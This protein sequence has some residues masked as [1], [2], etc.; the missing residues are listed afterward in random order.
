MSSKK[1]HTYSIYFSVGIL[2]AFRKV[3]VGKGIWRD[4]APETGVRP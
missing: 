2:K 1:I 3:K 4:T